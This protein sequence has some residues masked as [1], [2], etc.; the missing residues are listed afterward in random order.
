MIPLAMLAGWVP[1]S[2]GAPAGALVFR[3]LSTLESR[4]LEETPA[5]LARELSV[6]PL[7][8][9]VESWS[10]EMPSSVRSA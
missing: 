10:V 1:D 2:A 7:F 8:R 4:S 3:S 5:E 9:S 6:L